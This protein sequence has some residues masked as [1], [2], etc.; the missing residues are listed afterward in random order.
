MIAPLVGLAVV[1]AFGFIVFSIGARVAGETTY[2]LEGVVS[3]IGTILCLITVVPG[4]VM[5][6]FGLLP[7][8]SMGPGFRL[9]FLGILIVVI[10]F[11]VAG[12]I[13]KHEKTNLSAR[14]GLTSI[15]LS[16]MAFLVFVFSSFSKFGNWIFY[17]VW[18]TCVRSV[19]PYC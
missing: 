4:F 15:F 17:G 7:H 11:V 14:L 12:A 16:E 9:L 18:D 5:V 10:N 2:S 13:G 8:V 6:V 1:A 3:G 19:T